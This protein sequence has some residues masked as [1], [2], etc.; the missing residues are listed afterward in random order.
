MPSCHPSCHGMAWTFDVSVGFVVCCRC[1]PKP[2]QNDVIVPHVAKFQNSSSF[3]L[4][5]FQYGF[6]LYSGSENMQDMWLTVA[7]NTSRN[8]LNIDIAIPVAT[9]TRLKYK[10]PPGERAIASVRQSILEH[11][12][13]GLPTLVGINV[14][15]R[16]TL[17]YHFSCGTMRARMKLPPRTKQQPGRKQSGKQNHTRNFRT[18]ESPSHHVHHGRVSHTL[19]TILK[20]HEHVILP[21]SVSVCFF[22]FFACVH[23][24]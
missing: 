6:Q 23:R 2:K 5:R 11:S 9:S 16:I 15:N 17:R 10:V 22:V 1:W 3:H 21:F 18:L 20:H 7:E 12:S 19:S 8:L 24:P 14:V 4:S 13:Q